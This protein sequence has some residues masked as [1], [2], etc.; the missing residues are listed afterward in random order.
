M[1][2]FRIKK[3]WMGVARSRVEREVGTLGLSMA[4]PISGNRKG[5]GFH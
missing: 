3:A 5:R 4:D 1:F 2:R